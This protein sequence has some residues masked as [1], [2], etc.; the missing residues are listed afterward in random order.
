M[1][2]ASSERTHMLQEGEREKEGERERRLPSSALKRTV[3]DKFAIKNASIDK[4][5]AEQQQE[6]TEQQQQQQWQP[7]LC[8]NE[9]TVSSQHSMGF[10]SIYVYRVYTA[11]AVEAERVDF[12]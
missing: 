12:N 4:A 5:A 11:C 7:S 2:N 8:I 9:W 10:V 3:C 6:Q 1:S